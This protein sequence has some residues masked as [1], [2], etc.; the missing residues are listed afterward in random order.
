MANVQVPLP[1]VVN[2]EATFKAFFK[3]FSDALEDI[4]LERIDA[5]GAAADWLAPITPWPAAGVE[6]GWEVYKFADADG[7]TP[8]YMRCSY[9]RSASG[10]G[11]LAQ[12]LFL[13]FGLDYV[14]GNLVSHHGGAA[15][16]FAGLPNT[17]QR[18]A[19][20]DCFAASDGHGFVFAIAPML[21]PLNTSL[22]YRA[23]LVVDRHRDLN[24]APLDTGFTVCLFVGSLTK[25]LVYHDIVNGYNAES[26][27][28]SSSAPCVTPV[29][30]LAQTSVN[31]NNEAAVYP[32][33]CVT[34][35]S[36]T[37]LKMVA[38]HNSND[39]SNG[40]PVQVSW[41]NHGNRTILPF[42]LNFGGNFDVV[43]STGA[44][45]AIW[46]GD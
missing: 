10:N 12:P 37:I 30:P 43:G 20:S 11:T 4:G 44:G 34:K 45:L 14:S 40:V 5:G 25:T 24:G 26:V 39:L 1:F 18:S 36:Q 22:S 8:L 16:A 17:L 29:I 35:N 33:W 32:W 13:K 3:G 41:L 7:I 19:S 38:T 15:V 46:W 21:A 31:A 28:F 27:T 42:G 23:I 9:Q 2:T 6:I